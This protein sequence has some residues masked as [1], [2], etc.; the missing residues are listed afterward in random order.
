MRGTDRVA[1]DAVAG[2]I[3][4]PV[5]LTIGA[6]GAVASFKG[7]YLLDG[8]PPVLSAPGVYTITLDRKS[9]GGIVSFSGNMLQAAGVAPLTPVHTTGDGATTNV[10][11]VETRVA[12]GTATNPASGN[13]VYLNFWIDENGTVR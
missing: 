3:R 6:A 11:T 13:V 7:Q 5:T 2:A 12:A 4:L 9:V 1:R 10:I 8:T